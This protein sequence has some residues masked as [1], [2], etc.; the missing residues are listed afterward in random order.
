M[1]REFNALLMLN[2]DREGRLK[3]KYRYDDEETLRPD[4]VGAYLFDNQTIE[5][6]P[7]TPGDGIYATTFDDVIR[8]LNSVNDGIYYDLQ[9]IIMEEGFDWKWRQN[10]KSTLSS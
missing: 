8:K 10:N 3:R 9:D 5:P 1:V 2:E 7:I 4:Q 6:F